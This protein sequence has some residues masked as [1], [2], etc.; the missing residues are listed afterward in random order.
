[1][2]LGLT[3]VSS[4]PLRI[5]RGSGHQATC[6]EAAGG[7]QLNRPSN[8][9]VRVFCRSGHPE[10]AEQSAPFT[11]GHVS[12]RNRLKPV[13]QMTDEASDGDVSP[14]K[15][16]HR[17]DATRGEPRMAASVRQTA[18]SSGNR[19]RPAVAQHE[20]GGEDDCS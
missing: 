4:P 20:R 19:R 2:A 15:S 1:M 8:A 3:R 16:E 14:N 7:V 9:D 6:A 10:S 18:P 12:L 13:P 5:P 11:R 17:H